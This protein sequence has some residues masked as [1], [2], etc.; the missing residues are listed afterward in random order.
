MAVL[1]STPLAAALI[2]TLSISGSRKSDGSANAAGTVELFQPGTVSYLA[3]YA[4]KDR[5]AAAPWPTGPIT[6][7]TA[8][9]AD[10][11]VAAPCDAVFKDST[12]VTVQTVRVTQDLLAQMVVVTNAGYTGTLAN[13][14]QGAGGRAYLDTILTNLYVSLG[15]LDAQYK[16]SGGA[17]AR[18][19][20]SW[21]GDVMVSAKDFG[22]TGDGSTDDT[23]AVQ[24]TINRV[25]ARGGG[26]AYFPA[27]TYKLTSALTVTPASAT[28]GVTLRGAGMYAT[29]LKSTHATADVLTC[30]DCYGML[31]EHIGF[32]H[33]ATSTGSAIKLAGCVDTRLSALF[34]RS[35]IWK[36]GL[37]CAAGAAAGNGLRAV[38]SYF[39]G[40]GAGS[41][42]ALLEAGSDMRFTGCNLAGGAGG[43]GVGATAVDVTVES[44]YLSGSTANVIIGDGTIAATVS[45][46]GGANVKILGCH[47]AT[48]A[49]NIYNIA[50]TG[51]L[52]F[53]ENNNTFG[54]SGPSRSDVADGSYYGSPAW[55]IEPVGRGGARYQTLTKVGGDTVTPN[56]AL[57]NIVVLNVS[58]AGTVTMATPT[59]GALTLVRGDQL[60]FIITEGGTPI[61]AWSWGGAY[62]FTYKT[63]LA[64]HAAL[65]LIDWCV[66]ANGT[67]VLDFVYDGAN[68]CMSGVGK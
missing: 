57:G 67:G 23:N 16:E 45:A 50:A 29:T 40:T 8:G 11:F 55:A 64:G 26:V 41:A 61:T 66:A 47:Q 5:L 59:S 56:V 20:S 18:N 22:A 1:V 17:T 33:S 54:A 51:S 30:T 58:G 65:S 7:D 14:S 38:G 46:G 37:Y 39:Q 21:M 53:V 15:G 60:R 12:G 4:Y 36:R 9:K 44:S 42:G 3:P 49:S 19:V 43:I 25:I 28:V 48:G 52:G 2:P 32:N 13:G 10:V 68:W 35:A 31:I 24:A 63:P 62:L 27:G 34:V 6:L